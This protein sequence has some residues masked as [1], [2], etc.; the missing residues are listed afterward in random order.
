MGNSP[1]MRPRGISIS[2]DSE[3][4]FDLPGN[5][6]GSRD[7]VRP[8]RRFSGSSP[9]AAV[10]IALLIAGACTEHPGSE[11]IPR[12]PNARSTGERAADILA[13]AIR[14]VSVNPPGDEKPLADY[15]VGLLR[16]AGVEAESIETPAG[17]ST[18]GRA[19]RESHTL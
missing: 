10:A 1:V 18:L 17:D 2:A 15:F 7:S 5:W 14:V 8:A 16:E 9:V 3:K 19:G 6:P 12:S 4:P 11:R 13:H